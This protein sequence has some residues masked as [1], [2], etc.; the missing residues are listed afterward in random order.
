MDLRALQ[1]I[2]NICTYIFLSSIILLS[3]ANHNGYVCDFVSAP[4]FYGNT[5]IYLYLFTNWLVSDAGKGVPEVIILDPAGHKNTVPAKLRQ[6]SP[7]N[8]RCEY[9]AQSVGLHSVNVFFA[10][11]PLPTSPYGV[12][13]T[14]G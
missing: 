6:I 11:R 1:N 7:D 13:V 4:M 10:G 3:I 8:W 5:N 2:K 12:R 14:P 9:M